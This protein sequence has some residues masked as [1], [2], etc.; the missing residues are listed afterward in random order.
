MI[1]FA[2]R[3]QIKFLRPRFFLLLSVLLLSDAGYLQALAQSDASEFVYSNPKPTYLAS[4]IAISGAVTETSVVGYRMLAWPVQASLQ[5]LQQSLA[6]IPNC[7]PISI[8]EQNA[9]I[10]EFSLISFLE[11]ENGFIWSEA[12]PVEE[13]H[14]PRPA[15]YQLIFSTLDGMNRSTMW[16]VSRGI[17]DVYRTELNRVHTLGA[18]ILTQDLYAGGFAIEADTPNVHI[19]IAGWREAE[20][21]VLLT[22]VEQFRGRHD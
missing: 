4:S 10:N 9:C 6:A 2:K 14:N 19:S 7:E 8:V 21:F 17:E 13:S 18:N 3:L 15:E 12:S 16:R 20:D 11:H 1:Y 5:Q 22:Q